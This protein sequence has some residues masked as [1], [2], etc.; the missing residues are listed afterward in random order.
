MERNMDFFNVDNTGI[1]EKRN[2][3]IVYGEK[4]N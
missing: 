4:L 1:I 2:T 3:G